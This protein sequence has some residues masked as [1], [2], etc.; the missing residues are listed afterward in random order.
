MYD[1]RAMIG[2]GYLMMP[3]ITEIGMEMNPIQM[4]REYTFDPTLIKDSVLFV[5]RPSVWKMEATP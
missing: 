5:R 2:V 4:T 3:V 1:L